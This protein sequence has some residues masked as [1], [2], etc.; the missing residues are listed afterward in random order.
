MPG[1]QIQSTKNL[2]GMYNY[3]RIPRRLLERV[4]MSRLE[5]SHLSANT[6]LDILPDLSPDVGL[7][8]WNVVMLGS[9]GFSYEVLSSDGNEDER[10]RQIL[11]GLVARINESRG[12]IPGLIMEWLQSAYTR[13]EMAGEVALTEDLRDIEDWYSSDPKYIAYRINPETRRQEMC[14]QSAPNGTMI[15]LNTEKCWHMPVMP[16]TDDPYGRAI[17]GPVLQEV[18]FDISM[19][20]DIRKVVHNQG[21]PRID[22]SVAEKAIIENAP[23]QIKNDPERLAEFVASVSSQIQA[24]YNSLEPDDTF[25]H[26]DSVEIKAFEGGGNASL[27]NGDKLLR[28]IER[29][30]IKALK[31]LPVLMASNEGTTETHGTVQWKIFAAGLAALQ[32][33]I[34]HI[35]QKM[36][37][38]SLEVLGYPATVRCEFEPIET[39]DALSDAQT[40][41]QRIKNAIVKA[42]AGF[43][44]WEDASVEATGSEPPPGAKPPVDWTPLLSFA[45]STAP[46][47]GRRR[48]ANPQVDRIYQ[49]LDEW[50]R[51]G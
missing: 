30:M 38:F 19:M 41:A 24:A 34:A 22:I 20:S 23:N 27:L 28:V 1:R 43:V 47:Q 14:L 16:V 48:S 17:I 12:G 50:Y 35:L 46:E 6:L 3:N 33:P 21:W 42:A 2:L 40:E 49:E 18:W 5:H 15:P 36:M 10:G 4:D 51:R 7:A 32:K 29:R 39:S 26:N 8:L 37:Q 9:S 25:V 45:A 44:T 11:D 31:Q 13:G